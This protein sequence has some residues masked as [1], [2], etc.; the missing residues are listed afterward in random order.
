MDNEPWPRTKDKA[1][2]TPAA[3]VG[4]TLMAKLGLRF[5]SVSVAARSAAGKHPQ[6]QNSI[7]I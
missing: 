1:K 6:V 7:Y 3:D 2:K 4:G 5:A